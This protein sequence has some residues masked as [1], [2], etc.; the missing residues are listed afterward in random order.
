MLGELV[1]RKLTH[2]NFRRWEE[3]VTLIDWLDAKPGELVLD[4]GCGDGWWDNR[5]SERGARVIGVDINE[6]RLMIANERNVA[7]GNE[8]LYM[9]AEDLSFPDRHFDKAIS[10]CVIE[11]F[12][13][14]DAVLRSMA[15]VIKPGGLFVV[16]ADSLSNPEI[17]EQERED[18]RKRFAVNTFYTIDLL[19]EKLDAAGF[20][21]EHAEYILT[22]P[23]TLAIVR[24]SWRIDDLYSDTSKLRDTLAEAGAFLIDTAGAAASRVAEKLGRRKDSGLTIV[25]RARRR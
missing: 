9:D 25:A 2:L 1:Y 20:D 22:T 4:V 8:Y 13:N 19:R 12:H 16:S 17:T 21:L 7:N 6:R 15:R 14:E 10:M 5:I 24:A 23:A 11:H 18:H 3:C